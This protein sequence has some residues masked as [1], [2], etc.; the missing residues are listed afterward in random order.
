M[1]K[2]RFLASLGYFLLAV[3]YFITVFTGYIIAGIA[4]IILGGSTSKKSFIT[5]GVFF[6]LMAS[7]L[8]AAT[9]LV[10]VVV[11]FGSL[12]MVYEDTAITITYIIVV[13]TLVKL[14]LEALVF[15]AA[16][17]EW[18]SRILR[19][20]STVSLISLI[21]TATGFVL[22]N[23]LQVLSIREHVGVLISSG[24]LLALVNNVIAAIGLLSAKV[25]SETPINTPEEQ[26]SCVLEN[27]S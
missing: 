19:V 17:R 4:W 27:S 5:L 6:T 18:S 26:T 11:D 15:R 13:G 7:V 24:V 8:I 2:A 3:P 23:R 22:I 14:A 1:S 9:V 21:L 12:Q 20:A 10:R 25:K 16:G